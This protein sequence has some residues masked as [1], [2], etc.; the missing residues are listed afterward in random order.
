MRAKLGSPKF[1]STISIREKADAV[2]PRIKAVGGAA[3]V[4]KKPAE[5]AVDECDRRDQS[6]RT[7]FRLFGSRQPRI[8]F[9]RYH[10]KLSRFRLTCLFMS[11]CKTFN[12]TWTA[13]AFRADVSIN[14]HPDGGA[15]VIP[16]GDRAF[17]CCV[18]GLLAGG[19]SKARHH[20][21]RRRID[22]WIKEPTALL[23]G[24]CSCTRSCSEALGRNRDPGSQRTWDFS[25]GGH[26]D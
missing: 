21:S 25:D 14:L 1:T 20:A 19:N 4:F 13:T 8:P 24:V 26:F 11:A 23:A 7:P 12:A 18:V 3:T 9:V 16:T 10:Q 5:V 2:D 6:G 15:K 22:C 17:S